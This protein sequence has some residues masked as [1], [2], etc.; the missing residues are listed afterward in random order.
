MPFHLAPRARVPRLPPCDA[1]CLVHDHTPAGYRYALAWLRRHPGGLRLAFPCCAGGCFDRAQHEAAACGAPPRPHVH[2]WPASYEGF[3]VLA[4]EPAWAE[5]VE[6]WLRAHLWALHFR[7]RDL[8]RGLTPIRELLEAEPGRPDDELRALAALR[9]EVAPEDVQLPCAARSDQLPMALVDGPVPFLPKDAARFALDVLEGRPRGAFP[10]APPDHE[11][12][13][14]GWAAVARAAPGEDWVARLPRGT[15]P[16][17]FPHVRDAGTHEAPRYEARELRKELGPWRAEFEEGGQ[18]FDDAAAY[19]R[20]WARARVQSAELEEM[21]RREFVRKR[22]VFVR[23]VW[24]NKKFVNEHGDAK[25]E[26]LDERREQKRRR[27]AR[28]FGREC[29]E[30]FM[31]LPIAVFGP[32]FEEESSESESEGEEAWDSEG[33]EEGPPRKRRRPRSAWDR[34]VAGL[35]AEAGVCK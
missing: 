30:P 26:Y 3:A 20:A 33:D 34:L 31:A 35:E 8:A 6:A 32:D 1:H 13:P 17:D 14:R 19:V 4:P 5:H 25:R 9:F 12:G 16:R 18:V 10:A 21:R 2:D 22:N 11:L 28:E 29:V 7:R 27:I 23:S 15:A 24:V